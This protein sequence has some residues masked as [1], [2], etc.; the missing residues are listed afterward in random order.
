LKG[1]KTTKEEVANGNKE[2]ALLVAQRVQQQKSSIELE[3][4]NTYS[5]LKNGVA[6]PTCISYSE[7]G[8]RDQLE[9]ALK[10]QDVSLDSLTKE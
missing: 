9:T 7:N 2:L 5:E 6:Q 8:F 10:K 3:A 1:K 4:L